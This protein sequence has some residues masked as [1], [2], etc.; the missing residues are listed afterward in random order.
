M[1][2]PSDQPDPRTEAVQRR[3]TPRLGPRDP[4]VTG[5]IGRTGIKESIMHL[6]RYQRLAAPIRSSRASVG[7]NSSG[8]WTVWWTTSSSPSPLPP[9]IR[10]G[11]GASTCVRP[12]PADL[13]SIEGSRRTPW[14]PM[15]DSTLQRALHDNH[16]CEGREAFYVFDNLSALVSNGHRRAPGELLPGDLSFLFELDRSLHR[17]DPRPPQHRAVAGSGTRRRSSG[18][19]QVDGASICI[20]LRLGPLSPLMFLPMPV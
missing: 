5:P 10:D 1:Q 18:L 16:R 7:D 14:T 12:P 15:P 11:R 4:P 20:L 3:K 19:Y 8:R 9:A 2:I 17:P 6:D 13:P